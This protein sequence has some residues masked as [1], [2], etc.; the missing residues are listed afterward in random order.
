MSDERIQT[1]D[2]LPDDEVDLSLRPISLD[3]FVGQ[4]AVCGQLQVAIEAARGR[5]EPLDHVL[6][7]GPPGL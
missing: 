6:L 4:D 7:A 1:P 3:D 5:Q 2:L